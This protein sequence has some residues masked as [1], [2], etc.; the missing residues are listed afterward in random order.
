MYIGVWHCF[1]PPLGLYKDFSEHHRCFTVSAAD[2]AAVQ[3]DRDQM[4]LWSITCCSFHPLLIM[5]QTQNHSVFQRAL[6]H[7]TLP[8]DTKFSWGQRKI[9]MII[10]KIMGTTESTTE[11]G[12]L[13]QD[14]QTCNINRD[15]RAELAVVEL[16]YGETRSHSSPLIK[17]KPLKEEPFTHMCTRSKAKAPLT[18]RKNVTKDPEWGR[19]SRIYSLRSHMHTLT[20]S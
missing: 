6:K 8:I 11:K 3:I 5:Y 20:A 1:P 14:K 18:V 19:C 9:I 16:Q 4:P 7:M 17:K 13:F 10:I 2:A 12:S 15:D